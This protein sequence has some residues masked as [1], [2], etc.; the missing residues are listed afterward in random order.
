M[1]VHGANHRLWQIGQALNDLRLKMRARELFT[2]RQITQIVAGGKAATRTAQDNQTN[3]VGLP[4]EVSQ[5]R[6]QGFKYLDVEA[7]ELIW[8]IDRE[9]CQTVLVFARKGGM[10]GIFQSH[11]GEL[12]ESETKNCNFRTVLRR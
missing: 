4:L 8:A 11:Q 1:S 2:M 7:I 12:P 9:H 6:V 3:R 5:M 10:H